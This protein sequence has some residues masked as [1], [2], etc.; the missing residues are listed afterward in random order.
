M[1][2]AMD[3]G[4]SGENSSF[5]NRGAIRGLCCLDGRDQLLQKGL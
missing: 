4:M 5:Q 2:D 1:D 3:N